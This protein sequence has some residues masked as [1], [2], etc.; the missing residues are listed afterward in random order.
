VPSTTTYHAAST[1]T[2]LADTRAEGGFTRASASEIVVPVR[3]RAGVPPPATVAVL[4]VTA[5]NTAAS[6]FVTVWPSGDPIPNASNLNTNGYGQTVANTVPVRIGSDGAVRLFTSS[7]AD[8]VV[9]LAG[10]FEPALVSAAGRFESVV[11][12]RALDTRT[13][14]AL[15]RN[16][17]RTLTAKALGIPID[18]T[19]AVLNITMTNSGGAGFLTAWPADGPKPNASTGN[20]DAPNQTRA[21][22]S[23]VPMSSAG[24]SIFTSTATDLLVDVVGYFT[25]A[26]SPVS[27]DGLFVPSNPTRLVDTR[28]EQAVAPLYPN[29]S[30]EVPVNGSAVWANLTSV[31]MSGSGFMS[32]TAAR[33]GTGGTSSLNFEAG[34]VIA[35]STISRVSAH[36]LQLNGFGSTQHVIVDSAGTFTGPAAQSGEG[37]ASNTPPPLELRPRTVSWFSDS[38]GFESRNEVSTLFRAEGV[39]SVTYAG[40]PGTAPCDYMSNMIAAAGK[41]DVVML[42]FAGNR[43]TACMSDVVSDDEVADRYESAFRLVAS[44]H[45]L[46]GSKL[47][48]VLA[49]EA[50]GSRSSAK[51]ARV[52]SMFRRVSADEGVAVIDGGTLLNGGGAWPRFINGQQARSDDGVHLCPAGFSM[53][54][55]GASLFA[56][57]VANGLFGR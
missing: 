33:V 21:V 17:T 7:P 47:I 31:P 55:Y 48:A 16:E 18:A 3:G 11:P 9:D 49:P 56:A 37:L 2:R 25:G 34:R 1:P 24:V 14:F 45:R 12:R 41:Y 27:S 57:A 6:G 28:S 19:A 20:V 4:T 42:E 38:I 39:S 26:S 44:A 5:T 52:N 32:A 13:S 53:T 51:T 46:A 54:T 15:I 10:W 29:G 43:S 50:V 35:N 8:L 30:I 23:V 22:L 40:F 36:G